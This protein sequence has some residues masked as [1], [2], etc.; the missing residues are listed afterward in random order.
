[1]P[2]IIIM[3]SALQLAHVNPLQC[4]T[5]PSNHYFRAMS[6][7]Q[8]KNAFISIGEID[9][10]IPPTSL[11]LKVGISAYYIRY[12]VQSVTHNQIIF[13]GEYTLHHVETVADLCQRLERIFEKDDVLQLSFSKT[14]VGLDGPYNLLPSAFASPQNNGPGFSQNISAL[15]LTMAFDAD[16]ALTNKIAFL[17]RNYSI[18]H[19]NSSLLTCFAA[20]IE[21]GQQKI[22]AN[23]EQYHFDVLAFNESG[24]LQ[25]MNRYEFK[26]QTDFIYFLLLCCKQLNLDHEKTELVLSG[27]VD[28][29][30]K[31]YDA[32]YRY[33]RFISFI[34][35]PEGIHFS[36]ALDTFPKHLHFNLYNLGT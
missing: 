3:L 5:N 29:Q 2:S 7:A 14:L 18:V 19:L 28:I 1:M 34:R 17:F 26:T 33:F 30:S 8:I 10:S 12:F 6:S 9:S 4:A 13:F 32:C 15:G 25:I 31:V 36:K 27:E 35:K 20:T 23:I 21:K 24:N 11:L 22:F 16:N